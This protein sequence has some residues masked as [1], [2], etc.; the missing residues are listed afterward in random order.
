MVVVPFINT[1]GIFNL[2]SQQSYHHENFI[3]YKACVC[4]KAT[5]TAAMLRLETE[6]TLH[7][8]KVKIK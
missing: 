3:T 7:Y 4:D 1:E 2:Q 6:D 8:R 5:T